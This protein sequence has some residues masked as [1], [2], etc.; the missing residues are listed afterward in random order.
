MFSE[1]HLFHSSTLMG[2]NEALCP[3]TK[4]AQ[5]KKLVLLSLS[6]VSCCVL[7]IVAV[8]H[9]GLENCA[10]KSHFGLKYG[11]LLLVSIAC[12]AMHTQSRYHIPSKCVWCL[13]EGKL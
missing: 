8:S 7:D 10:P 3:R 13:G 12:D 9:T 4:R 1:A 5:V 2:R 11:S 6:A